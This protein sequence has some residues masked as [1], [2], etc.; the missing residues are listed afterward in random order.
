MFPAYLH[1]DTGRLALRIASATVSA[2]FLVGG[3]GQTS[4]RAATSVAAVDSLGDHAPSLS[5]TSSKDEQ[6]RGAIT[7]GVATAVVAASVVT[8]VALHATAHG[9]PPVTVAPVTAAKPTVGPKV[10]LVD[11]A[12]L[13]GERTAYAAGSSQIRTQLAPLIVRANRDLKVTPVTVTAKTQT[14]PSGSKHD[15]M[16]LSLYAWPDP[17]SPTGLP[18]IVRDGD[19]N[20][21]TLSIADK[22]DL[23]DVEDWSQELA[24]A[25]YFTGNEAYATKATSILTTFF[26]APSTRMNPNLTYAQAVKGLSTGQSGGIIDAADLPL[27][28]DAV[29]LLSG[30]KSWTQQDS[31]GMQAWFSSLLG[32][33]RT[34]TEGKLESAATNNHATWYEDQVIDY[35]LFTGDQQGATAAI[36][37]AKL[38]I[39]G[40]QINPDGSEPA[41][42]KR[43]DSWAYSTYN[44]AAL[45]R[46][47]QLSL[48]TAD[49]LWLYQAPGGA[50]IRK[51]LDFVDRYSDRGAHWPYPQS[52]TRTPEYLVSALYAAADAY[53]SPAYF[54]A[55]TTAA[56]QL[57]AAYPPLSVLYS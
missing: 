25:Y 7:G 19:R 49:D 52:A 8:G 40:R 18:Y 27:V 1:R 24:Y 6:V 12:K 16:S 31:T 44:L 21:E 4:V 20:P 35:A 47:A 50:S 32:W 10:F 23:A 11:G 30:S 38:T 43:T 54:A 56:S 48:H 17:K 5:P 13:E 36:Q 42:L 45:A 37:A 53:K 55:A 46:L 26:L 57:P 28:V 3:T 2:A 51:A 33:L 14:P 9:A 15:Y 39:I 29:G 41:E 34:S 22:Q